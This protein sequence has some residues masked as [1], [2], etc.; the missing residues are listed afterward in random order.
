MLAYL[1]G[2]IP[3]HLNV[4]STGIA[5]IKEWS[6]GVSPANFLWFKNTGSGAITL[7]FTK[8]SA[9]A[10][11]GVT[12]AAGAVVEFPAEI[13]GFYTQSAADESFESIAFQRR[14]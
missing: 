1:R 5:T 4:A 11:V 8:V 12:V 3:A 9:D 7:S 2:G 14:G 10:G 13:G 6:W